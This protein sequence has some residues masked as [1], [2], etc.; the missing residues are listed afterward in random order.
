MFAMCD[1][2]CVSELSYND[3]KM[4]ACCIPFQPSYHL[5]DIAEVSIT[6]QKASRGFTCAAEMRMSKQKKAFV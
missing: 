2:W 3:R 1:C 4:Q 5:S 6:A